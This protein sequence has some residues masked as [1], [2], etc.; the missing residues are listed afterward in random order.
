ME[1]RQLKYFLTVADMRS[2]VSAAN[3]LFLSRQA[4]SKAIS[5]LE[6]ELGTELFMRDSNGAFLTPAGVMFYDRIRSN[7][8]ELEQAKNEMQHYGEKYR[9]WVRVA[10]TV[11]TLQLYEKKIL[12]F[13]AEQEN[14]VIKYQ[15]CPEENL[16]RLLA[17][18]K[19]DLAITTA[20]PQEE[21]FVAVQIGEAPTGIL[22]QRRGHM[23]KLTEKIS[24]EDLRWAPLAAIQ[25]AWSVGF[26]RS[27]NLGLQYRGYDS[28]RLLS[29]TQTGLCAMLMPEMQAPDWKDLT[30]LPVEE[31]EPWRLYRVSLQ[32]MESNALFQTAVDDL[33]IKVFE[34]VWWGG[35]G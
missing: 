32:S 8:M 27:C 26:A 23:T 6:A 16:E 11:G 18:H 24:P 22:M 33:T 12:E 2:I 5:Q 25:N 14:F 9:H 7:V 31:A 19:V 29:L 20:K 15:E 35:S 34:Q 30:W 10:F 3:A 17:E 21:Q 28:Y 4:V 1:L 13:Q